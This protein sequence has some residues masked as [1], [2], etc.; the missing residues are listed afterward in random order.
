M[1]ED[2]TSTTGKNTQHGFCRSME[3]MMKNCCPD[4]EEFSRCCSQFQEKSYSNSGGRPDFMAICEMMKH[5][6]W[7]KSRQSQDG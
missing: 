4:N 6:G 7:V 2:K 3:E 5:M 1:S